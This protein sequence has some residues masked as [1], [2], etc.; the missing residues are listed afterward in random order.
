MDGKK[1]TG[2]HPTP[3]R[4]HRE[5]IELYKI[6]KLG[7]LVGSGGEAKSAVTGGLVRLNGVVET[8]KGKKVVAGDTIEFEKNRIRVILD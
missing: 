4:I 2:V 6:L 5:P 1:D 8:R 3:V 7:N